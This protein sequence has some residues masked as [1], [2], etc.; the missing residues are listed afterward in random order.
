MIGRTIVFAFML[1]NV[2]K[3]IETGV[4]LK[5][6]KEGEGAT[7]LQSQVAAPTDEDENTTAYDWV[8][9]RPIRATDEMNLPEE[10]VNSDRVVSERRRWNYVVSL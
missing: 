2:T 5:N 7:D 4:S 8:K 10:R 1:N 9:L 3:V 6:Q